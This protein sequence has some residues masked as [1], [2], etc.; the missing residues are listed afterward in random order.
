MTETTAAAPESPAQASLWEDFID[1][2]YA[3]REVFERRRYA[4]FGLVLLILTLLITALFFAS[5]GPLGDAYAAEFRRGMERSGQPTP[6]M[7]PEQAA[8]AQRMGAIFGTLAVLIGLPV[9]V[10]LI[11]TALWLAGKAFASV[12]TLTM[13][14][15][16][17]TYAQ[18][19]RVLQSIAGLVQGLLLEPRSLAE[20][21]L[22]PAR[23]FDPDTASPLLM[24]LLMRVDVFYLWSTI[25]IAIGL[26]VI[27]K[28]PRV[29]S[30]LAAVLVWL[31]GAIPGVAGALLA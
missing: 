17:V 4:K 30:Y 9:A 25:L 14:V 19:P 26:Q 21:I 18:F 15:L 23:F 29:Q 27:G 8:G 2:F 22:G 31:V 5:Q 16:I 20:T 11:G 1:I 24:A 6:E 28:V 12:A 13:S 3:P 7:S 10:F